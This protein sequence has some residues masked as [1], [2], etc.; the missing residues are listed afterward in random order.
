M[1]ELVDAS[2]L[3][4]DWYLNA[5]AGSSPARGTLNP[6]KSIDYDLQGFFVS[7]YL[8]CLKCFGGNKGVT[9]FI[10][11]PYFYALKGGAFES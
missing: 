8:N 7:S 11:H 2:D 4:S 6:C 1:A 3:K 9:G 10:Y 5:S